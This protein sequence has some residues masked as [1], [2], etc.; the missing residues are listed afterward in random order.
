MISG[1]AKFAA[2]EKPANKKKAS[3]KRTESDDAEAV[4]STAS[5]GVL[6]CS[7]EFSPIIIEVATKANFPTPEAFSKAVLALPVKTEGTTLTHT[8]LSGDRFTFFTDQTE[9]P[10]VNDELVNLAPTRVYDSPFVQSD[11]KSG[12]VTVQKGNR[13][14]VLNFN[15]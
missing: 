11:W 7:D 9:L 3:Q 10:R 13:K 14:I 6:E 15:E 5:G 2:R 8:G 12:L 4:A 1:D